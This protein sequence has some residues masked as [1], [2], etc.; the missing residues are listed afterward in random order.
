MASTPLKAEKTQTQLVDENKRLLDELETIY[1]QFLALKDE[2]GISYAQLRERNALL[3]RKV[4]QLEEAETARENAENQ[5]VHSERLAAMGQ[6]A[7]SIVHEL[8]N[9][10]T[11]ISG[12]IEM[13]LMRPTVTGEE[14]RLLNIAKQHSESMTHLVRD[15]LSF[16]HKQASPFGIIDINETVRDV[17]SFS[18]R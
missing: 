8:S 13:L 18:V 9:P 11:V 3:E 6:L 14:S 12:Y 16:S 1:Q 2:T 4:V 10:L 17:V 15:I 7:A 5:L